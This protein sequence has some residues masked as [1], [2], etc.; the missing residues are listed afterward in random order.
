[1]IRSSAVLIAA[2]IGVLA[3]GVLAGSLQLVYVSIGVSVVAAV[4]LAVGVLL[5]RDEIFGATGAGSPGGQPARRPADTAK[6]K[7]ILAGTAMSGRSD[8]RALDWPP[9]PPQPG[10]GGPGV[11]FRP[12]GRAP[13]ARP[14]GTGPARGGRPGY[15]GAHGAGRGRPALPPGRREPKD[16][17]WP[18]Q[19]GGSRPP[20][21]D[22][23]RGD[24]RRWPDVEPDREFHH[25]PSVSGPPGYDEFWE[26]VS[27]ELADGPEHDAG[28]PAWE[29]TAGPR[30][31]GG[32][33]RPGPA[34]SDAPRPGA[35]DASARFS[36]PGVPEQAGRSA[37]AAPEPAPPGRDG[38]GTREP[39]PRWGRVV[40]SFAGTPGAAGDE[41]EQAEDTRTD[42]AARAGADA[43]TSAEGRTTE[44][45][46][47][48]EATVS[49]SGALPAGAEA[50]AGGGG[51]EQ[52][53]ADGG[54]PR[55]QAAAGG[56]RAAPAPGDQVIIVQGIARYHRRGCTLIRF[57]SD[58]DLESLSRQEA[59][60]EGCVPCKACQPDKPAT[61]G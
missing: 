56:D 48:A 58:D 55:D 27:G 2:A 53:E 9:G 54:R 5:R 36:A 51:D 11:S 17:A 33:Q 49:A 28:P 26:R 38:A 52:R 37:P 42:L 19:P 6:A 10:A 4:L 41:A 29:A 3:A 47:G 61:D 13:R 23:P 43:G 35:D 20:G 1:M 59:M 39:P 50:R 25:E 14:A 32:G 31:M 46:A 15:S 8:D 44:P 7:V 57:L 34:D 21:P 12:G 45:P 16:P 60:A 30:A 24:P 40:P 22:T 18:G